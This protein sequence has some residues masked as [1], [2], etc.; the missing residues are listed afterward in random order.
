QGTPTGFEDETFNHLI[1]LGIFHDPAKSTAGPI[2]MLNEATMI[3]L[4]KLWD[5]VTR[6][7]A[8]GIHGAGGAVEQ[9]VNEAGGSQGQANRAKNEIINL[10]NWAMIEAG[11]G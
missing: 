6:A 4:A 5:T 3:P 2:Q 9:L 7:T 1:D 8:G 11:M 10:G